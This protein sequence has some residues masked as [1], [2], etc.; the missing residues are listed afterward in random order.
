ME[1]FSTILILEKF[2]PKNPGPQL[3]PILKSHHKATK[4]CKECYFEMNNKAFK[5]HKIAPTI[6]F[7]SFSYHLM[8]CLSRAPASKVLKPSYLHCL[9]IVSATCGHL[10]MNLLLCKKYFFLEFQYM[11]CFYV[12]IHFL[13]ASCFEIQYLCYLLS[14]KKA[15]KII[16]WIICYC[17]AFWKQLYS[18]I[19]GKVADDEAD[20]EDGA[21]VRFQVF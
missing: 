20:D 4:W 13:L 15:Y 11:N 3:I 5:M 9:L 2:K 7:Q 16:C 19:I 14:N 1:V 21:V 17:L 12:Y 10:L 18:P 8:C 6:Q